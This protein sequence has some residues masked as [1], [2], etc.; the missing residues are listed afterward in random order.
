MAIAVLVWAVAAVP[1]ALA[2]GGDID[3]LLFTLQGLVLVG[4]AV[5]L[6]SQHQEAVGH[7]IGRVAKRSL[8]VRL[9]LAYPLARRFRTSM[10]LGMFAL[11]VFILVMVSVFA[12]MFSGQLGSFTRDA[13]G[14]YNVV[15]DSNPSNP[16]PFDALAREPGVRAVA[17]LVTTIVDVTGAPGLTDPRPWEATGYDG[18][19]VDHGPPALD[20]RGT[21]PTDADAYRNVLANPDL[22]IIDKFFLA[23]RGGPPRQSVDIGDTFTVVDTVGGIAPH[24]HGRGDRAE[25]LRAERRAHRVAGDACAR[26][27]P[28]RTEPRVRRRRRTLP[29]SPTGSRAASCRTAGRPRRCVTWSRCSWPTS[30]NSSC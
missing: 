13:S 9:G 7:V 26:G 20:D 29:R 30:S 6:V 17:P 11:V 27:R 15:V 16:V 2:L 21:A 23:G 18:R 4:A 8:R 12:A 5:V 25:R 22:A 28:C 10:T 14:G 3:V 1:A 19:F 24:L